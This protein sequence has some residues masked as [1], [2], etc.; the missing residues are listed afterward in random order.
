MPRILIL[1]LFALNLVYISCIDQDKKNP[2]SFIQES[3]LGNSK[4]QKHYS[5]D[6]LPV[7]FSSYDQAQEMVKGSRF[8]F[9]EHINTAESSWI[10]SASYY[11]CDGKTGYFIF[12]T[13][14]RSYIYDKM[15]LEIWEGFKQA[16]SHG[17]YYN[18]HIKGRY[19]L[20][21]AGE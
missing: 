3:V 16:S 18:K 12:Y 8:R 21:L 20:Y 4:T 19:I 15:P 10:D 6:D 14:G 17:S 7:Q 1:L 11:S 13:I 2:V 5:C 9:S